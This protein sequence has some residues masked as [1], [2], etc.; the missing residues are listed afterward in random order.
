MPDNFFGNRARS[1]VD[2]PVVG[3]YSTVGD[4]PDASSLAVGTRAWV[5]NDEKWY[6]VKSTGWELAADS[7]GDATDEHAF[8]VY[9]SDADG[10]DF[11]TTYDANTH[12][13]FAVK[14]SSTAIA[15][16][17]ASDFTGLWF[18][19][20]LDFISHR[21]NVSNPHKVSYDQVLDQND[22]AME[23][24]S[25]AEAEAGTDNTP[26]FW[27][28]RRVAQA[29]V[30]LAT[31]ELLGS[32]IHDLRQITEVGG[33]WQDALGEAAIR[34]W[35]NPTLWLSTGDPPV[36]PPLNET[37]GMREN[38][39]RYERVGEAPPALLVVLDATTPD[40]VDVAIKTRM[41]ELGYAVTYHTQ[42]VAA[43]AAE[44]YVVA[45]IAESVGGGLHSSWDTSNIPLVTGEAFQLFELRLLTTDTAND[46]ESTT[47]ITIAS[48]GHD[49][50]GDLA[51]GVTSVYSSS[52]TYTHVAVADVP[53]GGVVQAE[54]DADTTRAVVVTYEA[55]TALASGTAPARRAFSG[56]LYRA[57]LWTDDGKALFD[58]LIYWA[59]GWDY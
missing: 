24:V 10:N 2:S 13:F 48:D 37:S 28:A 34:D 43:P 12:T 38:L 14:V 6:V 18:E 4:L 31:E 16:P 58:S 21:E 54:K 53:S 44:N 8:V 19:I 33:E 26:R 15:T 41:E 5:V 56:H 50:V 23:I 7:A 25:Q 20:P 32:T 57:D 55:G 35:D 49:S 46:S 27:T 45:V 3:Q 51:D 47:S 1:R 39:D 17:Q 30:A 9:A 29:I 22:E 59:T 36:L 42:T 11:S 40:A 52:N